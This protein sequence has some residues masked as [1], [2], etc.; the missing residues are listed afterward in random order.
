MPRMVMMATAFF[1]LLTFLKM[2]LLVGGR[3]MTASWRNVY[4]R[5]IAPPQRF[6]S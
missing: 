5:L 2:L 6:H 1:L 3:G 4:T